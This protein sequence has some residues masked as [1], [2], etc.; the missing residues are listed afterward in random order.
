MT[1]PS[2]SVWGI[3][4]AGGDGARL[5]PLT[6]YIAGQDCPKQFCAVSGPRTLSQT[7]ARMR[8][9]PE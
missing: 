2:V 6:R 4:L 3:V 9:S 7:L 5:M 1:S 8:E